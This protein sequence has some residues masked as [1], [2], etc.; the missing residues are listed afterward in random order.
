MA[1]CQVLPTTDAFASGMIAFLDCQAQTLGSVGYDA[2]AAPGSSVMLAMG[3][4]VTIVVALF[5]YRLLFGD[6]PTL[7]EGVISVAKIGAVLALATSWPAYQVLV[8]DSMLRAPA[9]LAAAI[10][11]PAGLPGAQGGLPARLD[12]VDRAMRTLAVYGVGQLPFQ[13]DAEVDPDRTPPP[14]VGFD[15][16]ALGTAHMLFLGGALGAFAFL[17]LAAGLLLALGPF[18]LAFLLFDATR[19]LFEGWLRALAGIAFGS[20]ATTITLGVELA[21]LEPWLVDLIARR[22][23]GTAIVGVPAMLL[24]TTAIFAVL[25]SALLLLVGRVAAGLRLPDWSRSRGNDGATGAG[26]AK[27]D[28]A[29]I[30]VVGTSA[31]VTP[32][33]GRSRATA[34]ADGVAAT[35]M[36]EERAALADRHNPASGMASLTSGVSAG[37]QAGS[38]GFTGS[39]VVPLGQNGRRRTS[40]R[41][42][43]GAAARNRLA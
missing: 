26:Q 13:L 12:G 27:M 41:V 19:G 11:T 4:L 7:R 38:A 25:L 10:G 40:T 5:G 29:A 36:R 3:A 20:V 2:L 31:S 23:G 43:A 8:Y 15:T 32:I 42:S 1:Y 21:L 17:R 24:A 14:F 6:A 28:S 22:A 37:T 35:Q 33:A 39:G 9:E 34:I 18:F 16:F 30:P